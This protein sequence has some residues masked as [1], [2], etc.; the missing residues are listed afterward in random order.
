MNAIV[1]KFFHGKDATKG[2]D[3]LPAWLE[4]P[5]KVNETYVSEFTSFMNGFLAQ[6]PEVTRDQ[7]RGWLI[8]WDHKIDLAAQEEAERDREPDDG[9]G[10]HFRNSLR[11]SSGSAE[12]GRAGRR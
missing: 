6:H 4:N 7:R 8:W 5:T 10:F 12:T 2:G 11:G 9:Y 3:V 1:A